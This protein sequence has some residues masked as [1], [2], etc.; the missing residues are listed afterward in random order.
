MLAMKPT[1][2]E[3]FSSEGSYRP[4]A[5]GRKVWSSLRMSRSAGFESALADSLPVTMLSR[6]KS[7]PLMSRLPIRFPLP[8]AHL[9][10][11]AAPRKN[12]GVTARHQSEPYFQSSGS[13]FNVPGERLCLGIFAAPGAEFSLQYPCRFRNEIRDSNAVLPAT[14]PY[15]SLPHKRVEVPRRPV[16]RIPDLCVRNFEANAPR[17]RPSVAEISPEICLWA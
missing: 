15:F 14:M 2:Q 4:T 17:S 3:S 1:P 5:S 12:F 16:H 13:A 7:D 11:S 8:L 6:S 9:E 10:R